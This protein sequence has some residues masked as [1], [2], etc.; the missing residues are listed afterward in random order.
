MSARNKAVTRLY[1]AI[2]ACI[3]IIAVV[4]IA[5]HVRN[6]RQNTIIDQSAYSLT[7]W[8]SVGGCGAGG[9]GGGG[10]GIK[11]VGMGVSGGLMDVE[12][13]Y[14]TSMGQNFNQKTVKTRLS[15]KPTWTTNLGLTVP[16][17]SKTGTLQPQTNYDPR[18]EVTGG[19]GDL[20]IDWSRSF[21]MSGQ[22][23]L[24][25]A[26]TL[27]TGQYDIK[28][29]K[30]NEELYL[31]S[32]LQKGGGLLSPSVTLSYSKDVEGGIWL[33]DVGYSHPMA[34]NLKGENEFFDY[35][36]SDLEKMSDEDRK[37]FDFVFKPYGENKLG[38]YSP[39]SVNAS[40]YYGYRGVEHFVHSFGATFSAP[41]G[42]AWIPNFTYTD[43]ISGY[44][45]F[46]DP[47]HKA[48][49]ASLNYGLEF[50]REKFPIFIGVSLPIQDKSNDP[51]PENQYNEEPLSKWDA[52][53]WGD[54]GQSWTVGIGVKST[55]F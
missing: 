11:W 12:V 49:T 50:S 15:M 19:L 53:D 52:P 43:D 54:L 18:V 34:L 40:V 27:P 28:R 23:S 55:M 47:D 39:P 31:P 51:D 44:K 16:V 36:E 26:V 8:N 29:G 10:G 7:P 48:W 20:S 2:V 14:S 5:V 17:V 41:L 25:L 3:S 33:Y 30:E 13:M 42:V 9:S 32:S 35:T 37:R 4:V 22:F 6:N 1:M 21:G 38:A 24:A 46:P 45:P